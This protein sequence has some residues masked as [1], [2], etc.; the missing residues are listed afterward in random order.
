LRR[1]LTHNHFAYRFRHDE[2]P[3]EEAEGAFLLRGFVMALA[4]HRQGRTLETYRWFERDRAP[5]AYTSQGTRYPPLATSRNPPITRPWAK[6]R[7]LL[8]QAAHPAHHL[9]HGPG[10]LLLRFR[11]PVNNGQ[12]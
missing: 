8:L 4:E 6:A 5:A 9:G 1:E 3:L 7:P 2:R 11:L 12:Y 10:K